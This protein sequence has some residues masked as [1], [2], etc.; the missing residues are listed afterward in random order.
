MRTYESVILGD[1]STSFGVTN[2]HSVGWDLQVQ[3][4]DEFHYLRP[5]K[6][7]AFLDSRGDCYIIYMRTE[8]RN[9]DRIGDERHG[10]AVV[11]NQKQEQPNAQGTLRRRN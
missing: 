4:N 6:R 8:D 5:G 1:Q 11:C 2:Y 3:V 9:A 7:L 10:F